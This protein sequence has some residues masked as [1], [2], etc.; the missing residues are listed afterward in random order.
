M[1]WGVLL[2]GVMRWAAYVVRTGGDRSLGQG[3][4]YLLS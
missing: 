3:V 4:Q 1:V 2:E